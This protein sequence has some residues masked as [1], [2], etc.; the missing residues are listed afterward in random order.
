MGDVNGTRF[1]LL[2]GRRDWEPLLP[3]DG[4]LF[5]DE[6]RNG[7]G[8]EPQIFRFVTPP[9][10]RPP[11]LEDH[12]G[13]AR[14]RYGNWYW[15]GED[16]REIRFLPPGGRASERFWPVPPQTCPPTPQTSQSGFQPLSPAPESDPPRL[17]G[18]AVTC[19][20]YLVVGVLDP[21]GLLVFDLHA[22]GP[23]LSMLPWPAGFEPFDMAPLPAGGVAILDLAPAG[24]PLLWTLDRHLRVLGEPLPG[25]EEEDD[26]APP[27]QMPRR[28]PGRPRPQGAP[29]PLHTTSIEALPDGSV[30]VLETRPFEGWSRLHRLRCGRFLGSE[31]V[32]DR[33]LEGAAEEGTSGLAAFDLA[34]VPAADLAPGQ[35]KGTLFLGGADGNQ[36]FAFALE[37]DGEE[38]RLTLVRSYFPM[39]R[40]GGRG[41]VA[42]GGGAHYDSGDRWLPLVE[43]PRPRFLTEGSLTTVPFDGRE[44]ECIWH[45]LLLDACIPE[46]TAVTVESRAADRPDLLTGMPWERE[47]DPYL[48][49]DGPELPYIRVF[50]PEELRRGRTGSWELL[51]QRAR[52]QW[53]QLRLTFAGNRRATPRVRA[54]RVWYPRFSYL[55]EYLPSAYRIDEAS[56][57][58]LDR[59]LANVEGLFTTLEGRIEQAQELWDREATEYLDW[60]AGWLGAELDPTW[61]VARKRLFLRH[62]PELFQQRGTTAGLIRILRLALDACVDDGLFA[63]D[64][65][66]PRVAAARRSVRILESFLSRGRPGVSVGDPEELELPRLVPAGDAWTPALGA[67][68]LH[69]RWRDYL[70]RIY[71]DIAALNAAW[72]TSHPGFAGLR[73]PPLVPADRAQRDD[74]LRFTRW[75]IGFTYASASTA[76][77]PAWR[78]F[79]AHRYRRISEL[80]RAWSLTGAFPGQTLA[81]ASFAEV[82]LPAE[83]PSSGAQLGDWIRFVSTA[84]P[85]KQ[86]AHRFTVLVPVAVADDTAA[87][88]SRLDLVRRVVDREKPAHTLFEV[89]EFLALF[90]VGQARVGLDTAIDQGGRLLPLS[91]GG[92][93][94]GESYL[95]PSHPWGEPDR[96]IAGRDR[97]GGVGGVSPAAFAPQENPR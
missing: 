80:H 84:L 79:L 77:A 66:D 33:A 35:V 69:Q 23:P 65:T 54:L 58:F 50:S 86:N 2:L 4:G 32:L 51:F 15:I 44:P 67:G 17:R 52:G 87:R 11:R 97:V 46:G 3:A 63:E 88:Q 24:P 47:P 12:R 5:F 1:H 45:R 6:E 8:L 71:R 9:G 82:P 91:L 72:G 48:R 22:G 61:D 38:L 13:A 10:D 28:R 39:R 73:L 78:A 19:D 76:D 20:H 85:L 36:A 42:A 25:V 59:Y 41:L 30:L 21:P 31:V 81:P 95:P 96:L 70:E 29:L 94:L 40:A 49:S 27:G 89:R 83:L 18:L 92:G 14:D 16:E 7:V 56:A 93:Y 34:F 26:F 60:L 43:A 68:P 37:L 74:W 75:E 53:L 90:R 62:A 55:K 57:S 64:V